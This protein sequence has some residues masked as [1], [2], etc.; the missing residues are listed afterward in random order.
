MTEMCVTEDDGKD[1]IEKETAAY[2]GNSIPTQ[3]FVTQIFSLDKNS[4]IAITNGGSAADV[5]RE[6]NIFASSSLEE[7]VR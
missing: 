5:E 1:G 2:N 4:T 7:G 6:A 3:S